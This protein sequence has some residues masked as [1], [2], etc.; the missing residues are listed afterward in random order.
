ME[1]K[2]S[3]DLNEILNIQSPSDEIISGD[4]YTATVRTI[5][6]GDNFLF[7]ELEP[8]VPLTLTH[9]TAQSVFLLDEKHRESKSDNRYG[10]NKL[11]G[12]QSLTTCEN[13]SFILSKQYLYHE[14]QEGASSVLELIEETPL[15][16]DATN[17]LVKLISSEYKSSACI[18][19][20]REPLFTSEESKDAYLTV[21]YDELYAHNAACSTWYMPHA[22]NTKLAESII[23]FTPD[24]YQVSVHHSSKKELVPLF[25]KYRDR[26]IYNLLYNAVITVTRFQPKSDGLF[27]TTFTSSWLYKRYGLSAPY[28]D[29]RLNETFSNAYEDIIKEIPSLKTED[30][31]FNYAEF[32][33]K[34][35]EKGEIY[36]SDNG[37]F[38]PDYFDLTGTHFTHTSLNHQLGIASYFLKKFDQ[39]SNSR[40]LKAY[41]DL[42]A[43]IQDT[44]DRWINFSTGDLYYEIL[45][46]PEGN[47]N[48]QSKDYT[49]VTLN[50]L[51]T[52]IK[53]YRTIFS[54]TLPKIEKLIIA[55][56]Q[57]LDTSGFG[58]FDSYAPAPSGEGVM[59][60]EVSKRLLKETGLDRFAR[61]DYVKKDLTHKYTFNFDIAMPIQASLAISKIQFIEISQGVIRFNDPI[62]S[63]WNYAIEI[64]N[65][66][67]L[68]VQSSYLASPVFKAP[69]T[70]DGFTH[71]II[72][73]KDADSSSA[74]CTITLTPDLQTLYEA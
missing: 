10:R 11:S 4:G 61:K 16:H 9:T 69:I 15:A 14:L 20:S 25:R 21:Y 60:K 17:G 2:L 47:W 41:Q 58:V 59:G 50:D 73:V 65:N 22:L 28:I 32:L 68:L 26:L 66:S 12:W 39:S 3:L 67:E 8:G 37:I 44:A 35:L 19:L 54:K 53:N 48:F 72:Y 43:F 29:T 13:F 46:T 30:I 5:D 62:I 1:H 24:G 64:H 36:R 51:L 38:F 71:I 70:A 33:L 18:I 31:S 27:L 49:Y 74:I 6:N 63:H 56:L 34:R 23:P 45:Q 40:Y 57:F 52:V 55:K 42:I 7:I